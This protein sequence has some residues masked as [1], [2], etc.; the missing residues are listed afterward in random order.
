VNVG[1]TQPDGPLRQA[2]LEGVLGGASVPASG[3][4]ARRVGLA[5]GG[6]VRLV[7]LDFPA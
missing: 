5:P 3:L 2:R 1:M 7:C 4:V 6:L